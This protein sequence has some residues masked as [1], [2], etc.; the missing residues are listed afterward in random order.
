MK[1]SAA[2]ASPPPST[3]T[4][5]SK[6]S[7]S[8]SSHSKTVAA[9]LVAEHSVSESDLSRAAA[10]TFWIG[11]LDAVF[12]TSVSVLLLV[13][14][15]DPTLL[16][17]PY[18][19]V[20]L[21]FTWSLGH[22]AVIV[23][24]LASALGVQLWSRRSLWLI[25]LPSL[26]LAASLVVAGLDGYQLWQRC[27]TDRAT[28]LAFTVTAPSTTAA[29]ATAALDVFMLL[30]NLL[31]FALAALQAIAALALILA[32]AACLRIARRRTAVGLA[33]TAT[34]NNGP[35]R[36]ASDMSYAERVANPSEEG[37]RNPLVKRLPR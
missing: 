20:R 4:T 35:T 24:A 15:R 6:T 29:V 10:A 12:L 8:S 25:V 27:W 21:F 33:A 26:L 28:L 2:E 16:D 34:N 17:S 23:L 22:A 9:E 11:L 14:L 1:S 19:S 30:A 36:R 18:A 5:P 3:T 32:M 13:L 37:G 31:L 7:S